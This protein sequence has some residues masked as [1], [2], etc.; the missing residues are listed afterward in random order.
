GNQLAY[1]HIDLNYTGPFADKNVRE[2]FMKV[3]P[4]ADIVDKIVKNR[5]PRAAPR[6]SQLFVPDQAPY[7]D[8]AKNNGSSAY[9]SVDIEGAKKLL[10]GATPEVRIMYNKDNPN[11]VDA[12]ALISES[13]SKAGFK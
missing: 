2:E 10:N 5:A 4:P 3:V 11:R 6:D 7:S 12:F 8:S 13:A 1:D 9:Q